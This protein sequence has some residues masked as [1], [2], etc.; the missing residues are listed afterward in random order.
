MPSSK[1]AKTYKLLTGVAR[2][3]VKDIPAKMGGEE[4]AAS[5]EGLMKVIEVLPV[6]GREILFCDDVWDFS[7]CFKLMVTHQHVL[8][9]KGFP[10]EIKDAVKEYAVVLLERPNK[11]RTIYSLIL[12]LGRL[13]R[14][15]MAS[16]GAY[17][18]RQL[19]SEDYDFIFKTNTHSYQLS[20]LD[21]L[22]DFYGY[23]N[24]S[25]YYNAMDMQRLREMRVRLCD[26]LKYDKPGHHGDI[27]EL[28]YNSLVST[29]DRLMR[30]ESVPF[31]ERMTA[32]IML[33]ESQ[34]GLRLSELCILRKD[35]LYYHVCDDGKPHPYII[36]QS[37]KAARGSNEAVDVETVCTP[38]LLETFNYLVELRS[39]GRFAEESPFLYR[40]DE[41]IKGGNHLPHTR[42]RIR[43]FNQR[44]VAAHV[45]ESQLRWKGL[46]FSK[47]SFSEERYTIPT[48][49]NF[50][51][52]FAVAM[53]QQGVPL[54]YV[55]SM[56]AHAQDS[57]CYDSYYGTI[58]ASA[59]KSASIHD[60][61]VHP[62][63]DELDQ[64][65]TEL[66]ENDD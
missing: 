65:L 45:P 33:V 49:H 32:G 3:L 7:E 27:P 2:T 16:S 61:A 14:L 15:A 58:K 8:N 52:H 1:T 40:L 10:P 51:V 64:Y 26:L 59:R 35:A 6:S 31:N 23:L 5:H 37:L 60:I 17:D 4:L 62:F 19:S 30:D 48:A 44:I 24:H 55:E 28:F 66:I 34:L 18:V 9:F 11:V 47:P 57:N 39:R 43:W 63:A 12:N 56:L 25:G 22:L 36:Y 50:R 29:F 13:F 53:F 41:N 46:P 38:L 42:D 20:Q 21:L 54:T